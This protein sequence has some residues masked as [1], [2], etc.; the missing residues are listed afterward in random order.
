MWLHWSLSEKRKLSLVPFDNVHFHSASQTAGL[1][2]EE[3]HNRYFEHTSFFFPCFPKPPV[4]QRSYMKGVLKSFKR[5]CVDLQLTKFKWFIRS[6]LSTKLIDCF[7]TYKESMIS[8]IL[9]NT[10]FYCLS[11]AKYCFQKQLFFLFR[12]HTSYTKGKNLPSV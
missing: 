5:I 2:F 3:W 4:L 9:V 6:I 12:I 7:K 1:C 8:H 10:I 11:I